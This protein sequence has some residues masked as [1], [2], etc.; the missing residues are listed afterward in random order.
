MGRKG[1]DIIL[2]NNQNWVSACAPNMP[3]VEFNTYVINGKFNQLLNSCG[4]EP[5]ENPGQG[6]VA[7]SCTT[8]EAGFIL[9]PY[10]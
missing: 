2:D 3:C 8:S 7:Q 6:F 5:G 9:S 1:E 10:C 4:I